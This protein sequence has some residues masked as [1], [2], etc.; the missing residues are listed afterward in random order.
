MILQTFSINV[1]RHEYST[2]AGVDG[3]VVEVP[4]GRQGQ[5]PRPRRQGP[6]VCVHVQPASIVV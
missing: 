4:A 3:D 2:V 6:V 5:A 1:R